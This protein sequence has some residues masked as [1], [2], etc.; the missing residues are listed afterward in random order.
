MSQVLYVT[1]AQVL[2][3][4]LALEL[5]EEAGEAPDEVLKAIAN[6]HVVAPQESGSRQ[7]TSADKQAPSEAL[8]TLQRI[9]HRLQ[10][11]SPQASEHERS[12]PPDPTAATANPQNP[13]KPPWSA[14]EDVNRPPV[15]PARADRDQWRQSAPH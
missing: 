4:K 7:R 6:A 13:R 9:E 5:S 3:A 12:Q 10:V 8:A 15:E 1:P 11:I 2:A 14:D